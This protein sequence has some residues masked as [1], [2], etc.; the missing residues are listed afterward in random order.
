MEVERTVNA[1]GLA[2][3][4]GA[5]VNVGYQLA[6]QRVIVRMDGSQMMVIIT[7]DGELAR[8]MPCPVPAGDR[9]RLRGAR[10]A[11]ASPAPPSGPVTVQLRVSSRGGIIVVCALLK[12][13]LKAKWP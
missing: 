10:K 9:Y 11:A 4:A 1:A 8:T 12:I 3:L 7:G 2:G 13:V 6:G 5:Q